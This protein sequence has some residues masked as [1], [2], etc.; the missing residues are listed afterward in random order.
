MLLRFLQYHL[1]FAHPQYRPR[2]SLSM[3]S[4]RTPILCKD[5]RYPS[6]SRTSP[7]TDVVQQSLFKPL[8]ALMYGQTDL[9]PSTVLV[10]TVFHPK[11]SRLRYPALESLLGVGLLECWVTCRDAVGTE[12]RFFIAAQYRPTEEASLSLSRVLEEVVW[13]GSLVVMLGG[14][15]A[16]AINMHGSLMQELAEIAVRK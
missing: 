13:K 14:T 10:P 12:Y 5:V 9:E 7:R 15:H 2:T 8:R 3:Q 4:L 11:D 6:L 16:F 1:P